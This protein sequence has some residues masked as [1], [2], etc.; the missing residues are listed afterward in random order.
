MG[1]FGY[2]A[3]EYASS[4]KLTDRSDVFSFGV[5]LLELVT[6]RRPVEASQNESLVEWARPLIA[7]AIETGDFLELADPR[8]EKRYVEREMFR[9]ADTAAACV[10]HSANKRPGMVQVL[11]ALDTD[12]DMPDINNGVKVGQSTIFE[13]NSDLQKFQM[14]ALGG[15]VTA[16]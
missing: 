5:V 4:G 10:R 8:L 9:M 11:R 16:E 7:S 6:G 1:T 3:H 14:L 13:A 2:M 15:D 12:G